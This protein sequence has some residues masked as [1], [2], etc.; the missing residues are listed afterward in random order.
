MFIDM[1][2]GFMSQEEEQ[3]VKFPFNSTERTK[4][5]VSIANIVLMT[6]NFSLMTE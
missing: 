2:F 1:K 6:S 4:E 3:L 5:S